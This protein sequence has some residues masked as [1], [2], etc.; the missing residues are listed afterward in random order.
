MPSTPS[1]CTLNSP[2]PEQRDLILFITYEGGWGSEDLG[3]HVVSKGGGSG[4]ISR[5][6]QSVK[7]GDHKNLTASKRGGGLSEY[8]RAWG[9]G[10]RQI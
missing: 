9:G 3:Y 5:R 7:E 2:P 10:D 6:W 8:Y 1:P 4:G